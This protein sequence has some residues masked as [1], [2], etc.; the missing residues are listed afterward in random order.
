MSGLSATGAREHFGL[1]HMTERAER[2]QRTI[3]EAKAICSAIQSIPETQDKVALAEFGIQMSDEGDS[4]TDSDITEDSDIDLPQHP[5]I[6][7]QDTDLIQL[8]Q[9]AEFNWFE[10]ICQAEVKGISQVFLMNSLRTC[11]ASFLN[12]SAN[13]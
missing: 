10:F 8:L 4:G 1:E 6:T 2:V 3:K 13:L 7:P 5:S 11:V 12:R 9:L